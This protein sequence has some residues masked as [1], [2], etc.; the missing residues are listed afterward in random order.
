MPCALA[1]KYA[2]HIVHTDTADA[3]VSEVMGAPVHVHA[4]F[5]EDLDHEGKPYEC[6]EC[7]TRSRAKGPSK[8]IVRTT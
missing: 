3:L 5:E 7:E 1:E 6:K 4:P 8:L 2:R